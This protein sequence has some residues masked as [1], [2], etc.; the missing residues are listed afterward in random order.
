MS[1][2]GGEFGMEMCLCNQQEKV[3]IQLI[4][5]LADGILS[6]QDEPHKQSA[7][8]IIKIY[9]Q[10]RRFYSFSSILQQMLKVVPGMFHSCTRTA[11]PQQ[12]CLYMARRVNSL[13]PAFP[14]GFFYN[15]H[16]KVS[17]AAKRKSEKVKSTIKN[18]Q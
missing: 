9:K 13:A 10:M 17:L 7:F 14:K 18:L 1:V 4:R 11:T 3:T 8:A 6:R 15:G 12:A 5:Y 2:L 16:P